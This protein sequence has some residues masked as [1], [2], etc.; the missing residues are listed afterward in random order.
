MTEPRL[1]AV[2]LSGRGAGGSAH[3]EHRPLLIV[4]PSLG[5]SVTALWSAAAGHLGENYEV[6][7]WELP[8][9]G[10]GAPAAEPFSVAELAGAVAALARRLQD[11]RE[12]PGAQYYYAGVS[13]G[14][15]V[16]L[17]L[18]LLAGEELAGLAVICSGA[19]I[20]APEAWIERAELVEAAGTPT[21]IT[22]SAQRW[23]TPGFME[24]DSKTATELLHAL[25]SADRHSYGRICRALADFDLREQ[26]GE[27]S[28]PVLT[29]AGEY[30]EATPPERLAEVAA[31]VRDSESLLYLDA[32]HLAPAEA[33]ERIAGDL[34]GFFAEH[35][36]QGRAPGS[37]RDPGATPPRVT[38]DPD[39]GETVRRRPAADAAGAPSR[40]A[41]APSRAAGAPAPGRAAP[42]DPRRS[43]ERAAGM[44]VRREVLSDEHVDRAVAATDPF[45]EDFQ[46]FITRNAWGGIWTRPGLDRRMR[47]AITLTAMIA[48]GH[49]K[50]FD[51]HVRAA[52]RNGLSVG[53]IRE[54]LL[55]SAIYCGVPA[56]NTAFSR[57]DEILREEGE[58]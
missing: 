26:L 31:G 43:E 11:E 42:A 52:L 23:F 32:A 48:L 1:V 57:A 46:D 6:V 17:E 13:V 41:G 8:G 55:Q 25:Q 37:G 53:E 34:H 20:G 15:A 36:P 24:R 38:V 22:G 7:G 56:A 4:G 54:V 50:E 2:S 19:R 14:G 30:D 44:R 9:H 5:T 27:I 47:S 58:L 16:G 12:V 10:R 18:A 45:T 21:Q 40:A 28:T 3:Q 39:T 35:P 51:L 33:P 49:W 29:V